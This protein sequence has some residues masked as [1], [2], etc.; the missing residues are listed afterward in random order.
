VNSKIENLANEVLV[1]SGQV[2]NKC[3]NPSQV[4]DHLG[5]DVVLENFSNDISGALIR[6]K[7]GK[8]TIAIN[9]TDSE[10][11]KRF[12]IAHECG[13]YVLKHK[14]ELFVDNFVLN[15][16]D[17]RSSYA[18]DQ[19]EIEANAFAAA[20]LMPSK[21]VLG[22]T[23]ELTESGSIKTQSELITKLASIF[24]VSAQAMGFRL[25]NLGIVTTI[26]DERK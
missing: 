12:S 9:K 15:K 5:I 24:Q 4:A 8:A 6:K 7:G 22:K 2:K 20:L 21:C 16:R 13:H 17:K 18:I 19:K 1:S 10:N 3:I 25:V 23:I 26:G 11:R 14:G